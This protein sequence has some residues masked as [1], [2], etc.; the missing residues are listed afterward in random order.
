ML[1]FR[2]AGKQTLRQAIERCSRQPGKRSE[3]CSPLYRLARLS[4]LGCSGIF[5]LV[6][7]SG[8]RHAPCLDQAD[9]R[10]A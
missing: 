2:L 6:I 4:G 7:R 9:T 1:A 10:S 8:G 5:A 3:S